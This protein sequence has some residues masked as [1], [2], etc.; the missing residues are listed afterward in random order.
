MHIIKLICFD[1]NTKIQ[2]CYG[3]IE[4]NYDIFEINEIY[5]M[6]VNDLGF[7]LIN[8]HCKKNNTIPFK[9]A[10]RLS[11]IKKILNVFLYFISSNLSD[12]DEII[13]DSVDWAHI[14]LWMIK[15]YNP[16]FEYHGIIQ[17][18]TNNFIDIGG[19]GTFKREP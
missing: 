2:K 17:E 13:I 4:S 9:M 19:F 8:D 12:D 5:K 10:L 11:K 7:D 16:N 18:K 1:Q 15:H 3:T 6:A 14:F